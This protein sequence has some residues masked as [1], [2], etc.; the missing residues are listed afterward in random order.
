MLFFVCVLALFGF[1]LYFILFVY[2]VFFVF[3]FLIVFVFCTFDR[4]NVICVDFHGH[5]RVQHVKI[6]NYT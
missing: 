4:E 2:F 3:I 1:F 5:I 6:R